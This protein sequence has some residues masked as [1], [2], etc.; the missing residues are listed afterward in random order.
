VPKELKLGTII[1]A[2]LDD[3]HG[4]V[5]EHFAIVI[6]SGDTIDRGDDLAVVGISTSFTLPLPKGCF[7]LDT[8]PGGH[9]VTGLHEACVAKA[10]W[11]D[12]VKQSNILE[13]RGRAPMSVVKQIVQ[14]IKDHR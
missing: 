5:S 10:N 1:R 8:Q 14:Y 4:K 9:P 13:I 3:Y 11:R 7:F 6:A 2:L 12:V